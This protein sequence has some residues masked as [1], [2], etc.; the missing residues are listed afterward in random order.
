MDNQVG[1]DLQDWSVHKSSFKKSPISLIKEI[2]D[3]MCIPCQFDL[4]ENYDITPNGV[5]KYR[6]TLGGY[7]TVADGPSKKRAKNQVALNMLKLIKKHN[8]FLP[9]NEFKQ[10]DFENRVDVCKNIK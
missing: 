9:K 5:F 6:L 2:A 4:L 1:I 8:P 7:Q 10:I 3:K